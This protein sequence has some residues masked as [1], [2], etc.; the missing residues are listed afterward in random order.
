CGTSSAAS[1]LIS[2]QSSIVITLP[3]MSGV[4]FSPA[5]LFSFQAASTTRAAWAGRGSDDESMNGVSRSW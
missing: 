3:M 4:H 5:K 2:A 1:L